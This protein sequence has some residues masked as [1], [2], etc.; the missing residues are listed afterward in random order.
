MNFLDCIREMI[1]RDDE[2]TDE[3]YSLIM[4]DRMSGATS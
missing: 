1:E 2:I 4:S 3:L